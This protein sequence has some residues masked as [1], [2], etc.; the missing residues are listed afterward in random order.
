[1][2]GFN[3]YV[4]VETALGV[5]FLEDLDLFAGLKV[6]VLGM[7]ETNHLEVLVLSIAKCIDRR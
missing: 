3:S 7:M 5:H 2:L 1:M 6:M 4:G